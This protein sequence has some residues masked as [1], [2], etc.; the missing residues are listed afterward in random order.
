MV[1]REEALDY[2][3]KD[4]K[5]EAVQVIG[6]GEEKDEMEKKTLPLERIQ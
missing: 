6:M 3:R 4:K 1:W 5:S 2:M